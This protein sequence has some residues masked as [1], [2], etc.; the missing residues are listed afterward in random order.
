M[1]RELTK[2][3]IKKSQIV[4]V[5]ALSLISLIVGFVENTSVPGAEGTGFRWLAV[6]LWHYTLP[7]AASCVYPKRRWRWTI[8]Y[9]IPQSFVFGINAFGPLWALGVFAAGFFSASVCVAGVAVRW[10]LDASP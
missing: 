7:F 5:V 9:A 1:T 3:P 6:H 2:A 8:A 4:I 10:M